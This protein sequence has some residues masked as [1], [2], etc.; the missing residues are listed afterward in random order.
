[1]AAKFVTS[2]ARDELGSEARTNTET[3][4][5]CTAA[6]PPRPSLVEQQSG[7]DHR[8]APELPSPGV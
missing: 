3:I 6:G 8:M 1:M 7:R 4:P 2:S 5:A